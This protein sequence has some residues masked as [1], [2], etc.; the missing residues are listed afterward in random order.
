[1]RSNKYSTLSIKR[2]SWFVDVVFAL[3]SLIFFF[4]L[5]Y[6]ITYMISIIKM[7]SLLS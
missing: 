6:D 3:A 2:S 1:M 4:F 7:Y 5:V